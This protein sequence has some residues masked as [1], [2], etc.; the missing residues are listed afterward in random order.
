M[1]S[2]GIGIIVVVSIFCVL[3]IV[4]LVRACIRYHKMKIEMKEKEV[5]ES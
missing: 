5:N 3:E 2:I 1:N 4:Q